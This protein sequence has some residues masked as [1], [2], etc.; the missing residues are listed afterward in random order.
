MN[1]TMFN[2]TKINKIN[3][4]MRLRNE[5]KLMKKIKIIFPVFFMLILLFLSGNLLAQASLSLDLSKPTASV[6]PRLYGLMTEEINYS[7]DGGLYG[8]LIRNRIFKNNYKTPVHWSLVN[9]DEGSISLDHQ[10]PINEALN[11]CLRLDVKNT[12]KPVGIANDGY[13][14]IPVMPNTIYHGSFFS[15]ESGNGGN[16]TVSIE[17]NNGD[18][19]YATTKVASINNQW[20]QYNFTL[21][22]GNIKPTSDTRF[23]ISTA[24]T[25]TYWFNL[26]SLFPPTYN[27]RPNGNRRDIMQI[28]A[29]MKPS[30]LR[31]PGGNYLEG[32]MF[33]SRFKWE[34]Q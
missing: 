29:D 5:S 32:D 22:T 11:V 27:N 33:M 23:L 10:H 17:S 1:S 20:H 16:L 4:P 19:N 6:S 24:D 7:Y 18:L 3:N 26:V 9:A 2:Q 28:L 13:W 30:F 21:T 8:E 34:K 31:F 25:G 14:G 15:K 12:N